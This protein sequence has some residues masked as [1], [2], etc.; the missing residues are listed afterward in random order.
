MTT[1]DLPPAASAAPPA[2][3]PEER[4]AGFFTLAARELRK[5][6]LAVLGLWAILGLFLLSWANE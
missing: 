5:N 2:T 4:S 6:R 3:A 1:P